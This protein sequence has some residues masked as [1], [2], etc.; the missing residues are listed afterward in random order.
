MV[1]FIPFFLALL[2]FMAASSFYVTP[3][4][5]VKEANSQPKVRV[6][7]ISYEK[8]KKAPRKNE[9]PSVHKGFS[10]KKSLQ[11][12]KEIKPGEYKKVRFYDS[13]VHVYT[14]GTNEKLAVSMGT[15]SL[16]TLSKLSMPNEVA[17]INLGMFDSTFQHGGM[18]L[19]NGKYIQPPSSRYIDVILYKN[20]VMD[21]VN[22]DHTFG[23]SKLNQLI[24]QTQFVVGTSYSLVQD[25]KKNLQN[26]SQ[27][28]HSKSRNP[29]SLFGQ[30]KDGRF[31]LV[32]V[33]GRKKG[34]RGVTAEQSSDIM[35]KLGC[36]EA[37]NLDGGGSSTLFVRGKLMNS[38]SDGKQR[39]IGS[40]LFVL[41][42]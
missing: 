9:P 19:V 20:G 40:A 17:K 15:P 13:D 37:V 14:T 33:D 2:S 25:G 12:K 32:T 36:S 16:E 24:P 27:F 42:K 35:L 18:W 4:Q 22:F 8:H 23:R 26:A 38:P 3:V 30:L 6:I 39:K 31:V 11:P 29:R 1:R 34:S 28:T 21:I 10:P 41:S 7:P 5:E